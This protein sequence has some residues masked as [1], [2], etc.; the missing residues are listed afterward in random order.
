[1]RK[2]AKEKEGEAEGGGGKGEEEKVEVTESP[3]YW[4]S[5]EEKGEGEK[6][7]EDKGGG[8]TAE[9]EE[10]GNKGGDDRS[11]EILPAFCSECYYALYPSKTSVA[12]KKKTK[13]KLQRVHSFQKAHSL[14]TTNETAA[15]GD[16]ADEGG[17]AGVDDDASITGKQHAAEQA[18]PGG[19]RA[20]A[21][22][23]AYSAYSMLRRSTSCR[24]AY[25][26]CS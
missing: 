18:G 12:A 4:S 15:E 24:C 1:M 8:Q 5:D 25:R 6:G 16:T 23:N 14:V 7:K 19:K 20:G 2:E 11:D 13:R 17:T 9:G 26:H 10:E 21:A 3:R 22:D